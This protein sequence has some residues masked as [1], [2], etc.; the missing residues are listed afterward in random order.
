[1]D[2]VEQVQ[3]PVLEVDDNPGEMDLTEVVEEVLEDLMP[4][5]DLTVEEL[6]PKEHNEEAPR[7]K[8]WEHDGDHHHFI[9]YLK[10]R[11]SNLP[12]HSGNTT[13]GCERA[14]AYLKELDKEISKAIQSDKDNVIDE[15]EA[16]NIREMIY[17]FISKLE[18]RHGE[19]SSKRSEKYRKKASVKIAQD[20]VTR[21]NDGINIQYYIEVD[22]GYD[23]PQMLPVS[24]AEPTPEQVQ[25]FASGEEAF[26]KEAQTAR[27]VLFEDPF[28]H[29]ITRLLINSSVS[30]GR[31]IE[32][33]YAK[34]K[35]K[36]SFT[37]REE[38][39]IQN[40]LVEKGM[41]VFKDF[42]R[43]S[44]DADPSDGNGIDFSTTYYA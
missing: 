37:P 22:N 3:T 8:D 24:I 23:L 6:N 5:T 7:E 31:N 27:I 36:Y 28:L 42:G 21:I 9:V 17:D 16:E 41:P 14:I 33:V 43:L 39:S 20:V 10:N 29:A 26:V 25:K 44:E 19:L 38:L 13:V 18:T 11:M 40:L 30:A 12:R 15:G 34:L 4:G 32:E 35:K 2:L 1:M